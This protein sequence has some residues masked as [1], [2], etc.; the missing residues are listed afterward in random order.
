MVRA[1][2]EPGSLSTAIEVSLIGQKY[3][4]QASFIII[5]GLKS[6]LQKQYATLVPS[7]SAHFQIINFCFARDYTSFVN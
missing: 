2:E 4:Q 3:S 7:P 1:T 6:S 5:H